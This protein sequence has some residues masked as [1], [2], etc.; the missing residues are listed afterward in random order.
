MVL[1]ARS[2]F[3]VPGRWAS[4]LWGPGF[5]PVVGRQPGRDSCCVALN[6]DRVWR[7][8]LGDSRES[9]ATEAA[10]IMFMAPLVGLSGGVESSFSVLD[11]RS[12]RNRSCLRWYLLREYSGY[13]SF[14]G[15]GVA[16]WAGGGEC[17]GRRT[18]SRL[19]VIFTGYSS[20][21]LNEQN[22]SS[23]SISSRST[24]VVSSGINS[25]LVV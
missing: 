25:R 18:N 6:S 23:S 9:I 10:A 13:S 20:V 14:E 4:G 19:T 16:G 5:F 17:G 8:G 11:W 1:W 12:Y 3:D 15:G 24:S 7:R 22:D 2:E 21:R